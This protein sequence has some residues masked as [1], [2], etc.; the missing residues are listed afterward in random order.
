MSTKTRRSYTETFKE[1]A[2]RLVREAQAAN[3]KVIMVGNGGSA[4]IAIAPND[5]QTVDELI[6]ATRR[7]G[8]LAYILPGDGQALLS[9]LAAGRP[10][11][12]LQTHIH[13]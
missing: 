10:V 11:L 13:Q 3:R 8:R 2:V 6:G 4:G 9:E 7:Q 12:L 1:E 5:G